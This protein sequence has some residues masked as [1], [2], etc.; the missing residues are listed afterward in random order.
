MR[1]P[2]E[3]WRRVLDEF[4]RAMAL[5]ASERA[6]HVASALAGDPALRDEVERML[7]AH[8]KAAG[9]L[10]TPAALP[11]DT[12][13]AQTLEG[14]RIGPYLLSSRIGS[15]GMGVVYKA[16]DTR[17]NR[18][19]AIKVLP[20]AVADDAETRERFDREGRAIA[21]LNHPHIC[22]LYDVG[23]AVLPDREPVAPGQK[24]RL[25][26]RFL[27]MEYL[28]GETLSDRMARGRLTSAQALEIAAQMA[29][30]LDAAHR[31]G[32]VHRDLKPGNVFLVRGGASGAPTAKLLDFGLAKSTP[33]TKGDVSTRL[34]M[35]ANLTAP[36]TIM[37]TVQYMAPEQVEGKDTDARTDIFAF[38]AVLYE[39]LTGARAFSGKNQASVMVAIL[40]QDP[41]PLSDAVPSA[42]PL[43]DRVVR[44]CLAKDPDARWQSAADVASELQWI[45]QAGAPSVASRT[46]GGTGTGPRWG[47]IALGTMAT[48]ALIATISVLR[49]QASSS[50]PVTPK[51]FAVT[52]PD[53]VQSVWLSTFALLP[54]G[55]G[56]VYRARGVDQRA[57]QWTL[58]MLS[59]GVLRPLPGTDAADNAFLS[60]DGAW[61]GF[62]QG[63][64]L[65]KLAL[66]GGAPVDVCETPGADGGSWGAD[67]RIVFSRPDGLWRVPA[68]GG[69][70]ERVTSLAAGEW[71]HSQ[72]VVLPG[73]DAVLFTALSQTGK[74]E[75][76]TIGAVS[77]RN[78]ERRLLVKGATSPRYA[79]TGHLLYTRGSDLFAVAL[80][81]N[82][83]AVTGKHILV[84]A[85]VQYVPQFLH[86][87]YDLATDGTLAYL[88]AGAE[89]KRTLVWMDRSG[90]QQPLPVPP[91]PYSHPALLPDGKGLI[92]EIEGSPHNLWRYEFG[93][94]AMMPLTH[95][96][97]N[98]RPVLSPDGRFMAFSS[99]RTVPRS[100]F[101]QATDGSSDAEHLL[102]APHA[103]NMTSWS[104][105]GRWIA[106]T[107]THPQRRGDIWVL[108]L[109]GDRA[110]HPILATSFSEDSAI[111]SPDGHWIAYTSDESGH[112]EVLIT[113]FPGPG[114]RKQVSTTGGTQPL[115]SEDGRSVFYRQGDRIMSAEIVTAPA[116]TI[117]APRVAF[118]IPEAW[119]STLP[120]PVS[121]KGD[122][123]LYIKVAGDAPAPRT[124]RIIVN[125]FDEL[126]RLT[127]ARQ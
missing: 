89:L 18:T 98:H 4:E 86:A 108:A 59:D 8:G 104:R 13:S 63:G 43:L 67:D 11:D 32:I 22:S 14:E 80:D 111:F 118:E 9:F 101:R 40:E 34:A 114:P 28:E 47:L 76:A 56:F 96:S 103:H 107:E 62:F 37:G 7:E 25:P 99:D 57:T 26:L 2:P 44:K 77:L 74:L 15:G 87:Q 49:R 71:V 66:A 88:P 94:G 27:V 124:A 30:A 95:D 100:L 46:A 42:A 65:K 53:A 125:W 48:I 72:P 31:A 102:N 51:Q 35:A 60:H 73:G 83:L 122:R 113:A 97:P 10:S 24:P 127:A 115:F 112:N 82:P 120:F 119:T 78:G 29:M 110:A 36:G 126:R 64:R 123:V 21:A 81:R 75:D 16:Q 121:P 54:D 106:F 33:R 68:S 20:Q 84:V 109:D 50:V 117:G 70:P 6:A 5:P 38:G 3:D 61:L 17:L 52:L 105:D 1:L 91:Q 92:V 90:T 79:S 41:A 93:S 19:V 58:Q 39:M 69:K 55:S 45:A 85:G 116:L 23:E 12:S